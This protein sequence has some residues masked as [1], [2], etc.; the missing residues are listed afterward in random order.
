MPA[1]F[2][3]T[4]RSLEADSFLGWWIGLTVAAALLLA[5]M[6]WFLCGRITVYRTSDH[7]W[8]ETLG[9][10]HPIDA[11]VAG[12]IMKTSLVLARQVHAGQTLVELDSRS[13]QLDLNEERARLTALASERSRLAAEIAAEGNALQRSREAGRWSLEQARV[14]QARTAKVASIAD[15]IA[16]R[17]HALI[18]ARVGAQ[19]LYLKALSD[20]QQ[21]DASADA[22]RLELTRLQKDLQSQEDDRVAHIAQLDRKATELDGARAIARATV[23]RIEHEI[24]IRH[25]RAP[26]DGQIGNIAPDI[27][28][29]AFVAEGRRLCAIIPLQRVIAV[30]E[31]VP[32]S[33]LGLIRPG[34]PATLRLRGF[35]WAQFG[36]V[37]ARVTDVASEPRHGRIRVEFSVDAD[38]RRIP[39]Q[40]GLPGTIEVAVERVSQAALLLRAAGQLMTRPATAG[41]G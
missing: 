13:Q 4:A 12:R 20:A 28:A 36:S 10:V 21:A 33:A 6:L 5:W 3:R 9:R 41:D 23:A 32:W 30:A 29:G 11:A 26:I 8:L 39:F 31:F 19:V 27:R 34:Q 15:D 7:A 17:Y 22:A 38:D 37:P 18:Q 1:Q 35:P 24:E 40:N 2:V 25:L 14:D 16:D